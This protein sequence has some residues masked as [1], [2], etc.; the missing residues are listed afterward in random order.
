MSKGICILFILV[1]YEFCSLLKVT[2]PL[3]AVMNENTVDFKEPF[4]N[5]LKQMYS[6]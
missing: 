1:E 5:H 6:E 2:E 3:V 4:K